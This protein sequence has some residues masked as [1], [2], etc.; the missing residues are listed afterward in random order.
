MKN[1][2]FVVLSIL[3]NTAAVAGENK[4]ELT[5][6]IISLMQ[7]DVWISRG[8]NLG[9][10]NTFKFSDNKCTFVAESLSLK[11]NEKIT[12]EY[13][14]EEMNVFMVDA[15][16]QRQNDSRTL[17][18]QCRN[19]AQCIKFIAGGQTINRAELSHQH[20]TNN[21]RLANELEN[22]FYALRNLCSN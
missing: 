7:E 8:D 1:V 13:P 15:S 20:T 19:A 9:Y 14:L 21:S 3:V 12:M 5:A 22:K 16:T 11:H 17:M 4:Q 10:Q 18:F 6:G 2:F